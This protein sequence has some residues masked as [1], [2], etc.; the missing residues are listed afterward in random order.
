[1]RNAWLGFLNGKNDLG[2]LGD[3]ELNEIE[4]DSKEILKLASENHVISK[5]N[6]WLGFFKGKFDLGSLGNTQLNE[7]DGANRKEALN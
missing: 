3:T 6:A 7:P 1:M 5:R 4:V 2:S